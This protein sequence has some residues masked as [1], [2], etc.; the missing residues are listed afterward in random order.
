MTHRVIYILAFLQTIHV[1]VNGK[2]FCNVACV[3]PPCDYPLPPPPGQ[4]CPICPK[5]VCNELCVRPSCDK[6]LPPLPG[7][8]CPRCP[9]SV[10]CSAVLCLRP[11]CD[12]PLSPLPGECCP[13]KGWD[14]RQSIFCYFSRPF[15]WLPDN[16]SATSPASSRHAKIRS[17]L[18]PGNAAPGAPTPWIA[19]LFF[20]RWCYAKS[21]SLL[22]PEN[23]ALGVPWIAVSFVV[24]PLHAKIHSRHLPENAAPGAPWIAAPFFA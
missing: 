11:P 4:C 20:A 3:K 1:A 13:R 24:Q 6:P 17:H 10:D 16:Q 12:N 5:R 14:K 2:V 23:A 18:F 19:V 21:R 9:T 22:P 15:S 8:C 7:E